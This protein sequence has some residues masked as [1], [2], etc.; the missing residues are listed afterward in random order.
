MDGA[1]EFSFSMSP[2]LSMFLISI[3]LIGFYALLRFGP[4]T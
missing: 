3:S 4:K 2:E 1:Y